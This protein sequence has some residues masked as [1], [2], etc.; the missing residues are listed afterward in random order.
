MDSAQHNWP[1]SQA[2]WSTSKSY[3]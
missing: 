3:Q 2:P 1:I